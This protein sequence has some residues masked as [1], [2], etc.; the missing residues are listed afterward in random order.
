MLLL[1]SIRIGPRDAFDLV[2]LDLDFLSWIADDGLERIVLLNILYALEALAEGTELWTELESYPLEV[3]LGAPYLYVLAVF[4]NA[5][6]FST[7]VD[8]PK[9]VGCLLDVA[10]PRRM[11]DGRR[12]NF[13]VDR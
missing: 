9:M 8:R 4:F 2:L 3:V 11:R 12:D 1:S 5:L 7:A 10:A 13:M 6:A